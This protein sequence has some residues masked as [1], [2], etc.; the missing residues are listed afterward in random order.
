MQFIPLK[1]EK[2]QVTTGNVLPLLLPHFFTYFFNSKSVSFVEGRRKNISCPRA[3][4]T[5]AMQLL[6]FIKKK[7]TFIR[8]ML[9]PFLFVTQQLNF[10]TLC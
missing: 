6:I 9:P 3:Q 10:S 1:K 8:L 2:Q 4:G 7:Q 5:L